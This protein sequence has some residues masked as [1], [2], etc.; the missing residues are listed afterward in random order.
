MLYAKR[1]ENGKIIA[2][3]STTLSDSDEIVRANDE[4]VVE[5]I[6]SNA[7]PD[8]S[9]NYLSHTDAEMIRIVEDLV[10][11]LIEKNL[12]MLTDLPDA[13][14]DKILARKQ[15]RS[16][17]QPGSQLLVDEDDLF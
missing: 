3:S 2:L 17:F 12:I 8:L 15:I 10:E 14:R 5:F 7:S 6:F 13:A 4:D 9:K 1:G 16:Q 11:L